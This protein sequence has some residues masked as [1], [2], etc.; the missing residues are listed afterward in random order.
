MK[1]LF[2]KENVQERNIKSKPWRSKRG[3]EEV[4]KAIQIKKRKHITDTIV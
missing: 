1:M 3:N 2:L 4:N